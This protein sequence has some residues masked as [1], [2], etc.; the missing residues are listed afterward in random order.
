[1]PTRSYQPTIID[2]RLLLER[3]AIQIAFLSH[4]LQR[5]WIDF[6][7]DP[8]AFATRSTPLLLRR[9]TSLLSRLQ[10]MAIRTRSP[11][12]PPKA[13]AK[14]AESETIMDWVLGPA[15]VQALD[16]A[17]TETLV[18]DLDR[19]VPA[20]REVPQVQAGRS[21]RRKYGLTERAIAAA[22]Q[23]RFVPAMKNG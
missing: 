23:I 11:K 2:N 1:M 5:A 12:R 9:F 18:A 17:A 3:L 16:Q 4:E 13:R 19:P 6:K 10:F 21:M 7:N 20:V 15:M 14:E 22:H 8:I